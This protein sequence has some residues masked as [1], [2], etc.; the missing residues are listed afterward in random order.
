PVGI[1]N[2]RT[3]LTTL[4]RDG[5]VRD[6]GTHPER[7]EASARGGLQA[8]HCL[9]ALPGGR[10]RACHWFSLDRGAAAHPDWRPWRRLDRLWSAILGCRDH[11]SDEHRRAAAEQL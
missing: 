6:A 11:L 5:R 1:I 2:E 9:H 7:R 10:P 4:W 3:P 8:R